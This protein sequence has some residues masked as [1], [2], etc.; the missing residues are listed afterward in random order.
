MVEY[1]GRLSPP[2]NLERG[3]VVEARVRRVGTRYVAERMYLVRNVRD[4]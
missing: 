3:D 1:Q 4:Y 2:T